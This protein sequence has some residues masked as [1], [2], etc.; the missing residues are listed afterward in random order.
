MGVQRS[1]VVPADKISTNVT[2]DEVPGEIL[3]GFS[4]LGIEILVV[5][6]DNKD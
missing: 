5:L 2:T 1:P 6:P 3:Q 4:E